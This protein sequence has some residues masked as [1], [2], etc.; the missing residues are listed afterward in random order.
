MRTPPS[1]PVPPQVAAVRVTGPRYW[2]QLLERRGAGRG[3]GP[4][5]AAL[6]ATRTLFVQVIVSGTVRSRCMLDVGRADLVLGC[7]QHPAA[8][9]DLVPLCRLLQRK[10]GALPYADDPSGEPACAA[11]TVGWSQAVP[12][13]PQPTSSLQHKLPRLMY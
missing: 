4:S 11:P 13:Q 10:A 6:Y 2:H 5:L 7:G 3:R 12:H 8:V 1:L 9:Y